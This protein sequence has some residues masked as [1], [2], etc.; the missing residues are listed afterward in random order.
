MQIDDSLVLHI[1]E[2]LSYNPAEIKKS[3]EAN[4]QNSHTTTYKLL[5]KKWLLSDKDSPFDYNSENFDP[6]LL[7]KPQIR[8]GR[9]SLSAESMDLIRN[10]L[11]LDKNNTKT[12]LQLMPRGLTVEDKVLQASTGGTSSIDGNLKRM[13]TGVADTEKLSLE[14]YNMSRYKVENKSDQTPANIVI[15]TTQINVDK[16]VKTR[17]RKSVV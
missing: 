6:E 14:K 13:R 10:K 11:T 9:I 1:A 17:D 8:S 5:M 16:Q 15:T 7:K 12:C 4:S 2:T 3:I